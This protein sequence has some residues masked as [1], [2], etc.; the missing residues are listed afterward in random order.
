M[1]FITDKYFKIDGSMN[2]KEATVACALKGGRLAN[3]MDR[4]ENQGVLAALNGSKKWHWIGAND[5][6]KEGQW[7]WSDGSKLGCYK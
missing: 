3:I 4:M 6:K 1:H 2:Y 5:I 7:R